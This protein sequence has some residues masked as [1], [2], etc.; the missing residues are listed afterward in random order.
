MC[1]VCRKQ[2]YKE[3]PV[4]RMQYHK[5]PEKRREQDRKS[6]EKRREY[7]R[8]YNRAYRERN[9]ESE[10]KRMREYRENNKELFNEHQKKRKQMELILDNLHSD[11]NIDEVYDYFAEECCLTG[12]TENVTLDHFIPV[13]WGHGGTHLGN[14]YPLEMV[15]NQTKNRFNPFT[16][17]DWAKDKYNIDIHK[18]NKLIEALASI[19]GLTVDEFKDFV[20]WCEDNKRTL[21][22]IQQHPLP[23]LEL[24]KSVLKVNN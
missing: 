14:M 1:K 5:D 23:S 4:Q 22:D 15:I 24:W 6:R 7:Y 16:W 8:E 21:E 19:N 20:Y 17:F 2:E 9:Y 10:I 11:F 3:N 12:T 13:S 18:W